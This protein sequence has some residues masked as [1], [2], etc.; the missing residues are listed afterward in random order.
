MWLGLARPGTAERDC[1]GAPRSRPQCL[2]SLDSSVPLDS[3]A[4]GEADAEEEGQTGL[5]ISNR[6]VG[7]SGKSCSSAFTKAVASPVRTQTCESGG[8]LPSTDATT[9]VTPGTCTF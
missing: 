4:A 8:I 3:F 6:H 5:S 7:P 1:R 9:P 2:P